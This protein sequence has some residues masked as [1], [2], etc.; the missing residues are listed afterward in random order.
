[1]EN[2]NNDEVNDEPS[3]ILSTLAMFDKLKVPMLKVFYCCRL[4]KDLKDKINIPNKGNMTKVCAW[5]INMKTNVPLLIQLYFDVKSLPVCA[6][7]PQLPQPE[8]GI[9]SVHPPTILSFQTTDITQNL[10]DCTI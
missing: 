4:Q 9:I 2:L 3:L 8:S 6:K 5:E 7:N 10:D 1:M